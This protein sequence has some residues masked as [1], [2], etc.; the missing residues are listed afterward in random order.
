MHSGVN[1]R[2][3]TGLWGGVMRAAAITPSPSS[4][5]ARYYPSWK[6]SGCLTNWLASP[7]IKEWQA[8]WRS[9]WRSARS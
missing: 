8:S 7:S 5:V 2:E 6:R 4:T 1:P 9:R 3:S